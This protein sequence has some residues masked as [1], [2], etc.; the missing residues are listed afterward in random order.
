MA[1]ARVTGI[2]SLK[3]VRVLQ[4]INIWWQSR[5]FYCY[6]P[7]K[8]AVILDFIELVR[9]PCFSGEAIRKSDAEIG[10]DRHGL[11]GI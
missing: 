3:N 7:T 2:N 4:T 5:Q 10:V 9:L 8:V 6:N 1:F 11:E